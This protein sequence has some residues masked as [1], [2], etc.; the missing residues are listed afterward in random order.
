[1]SEESNE[2]LDYLREKSQGQGLRD[3]EAQELADLE[4]GGPPPV[5]SKLLPPRLPGRPWRREYWRNRDLGPLGGMLLVILGVVIV[6]VAAVTRTPAVDWRIYEDPAFTFAV[7]Y[8]NGWT[9][10][11]VSE[12]TPAENGEKA[13]RVDGVVFAQSRI[14]PEAL[15]GAL[16]AGY[17]GPAYGIVVYKPGPAAPLGG[18]Q[19]GSASPS[20]VRVG[21]LP[22]Q[23]YTIETDGVI[24]T[25]AYAVV[26]GRLV[27]FFF[28]VPE[29]LADGLQDVFDHARD[30]LRLSEGLEHTPS[31]TPTGIKPRG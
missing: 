14:T 7:E 23:E 29:A 9:A 21:G 17:H 8:P 27:V 22:A 30:S 15:A 12:R 26:K 2:R 18:P 4:R 24:T 11:S 1:V 28:K 3:R 25:T 5:L 6:A 31:P 10:T 19:P 13:R 20:D 16:Q